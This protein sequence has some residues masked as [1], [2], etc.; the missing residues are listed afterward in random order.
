[1]FTTSG[2]R[3]A[4]IAII[5]SNNT[6]VARVRQALSE[7]TS[8]RECL[9]KYR[10]LHSLSGTRNA[11]EGPNLPHARVRL[12]RKRKYTKA[13]TIVQNSTS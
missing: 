1:M 4:D 12:A 10:L 3:K 13:K 9:E 8:A 6:M 7:I 5:T 11:K 2:S